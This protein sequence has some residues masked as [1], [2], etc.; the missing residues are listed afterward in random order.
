MVV[1]NKSMSALCNG[2]L[3]HHDP[4]PSCQGKR[5]IF[6]EGNIG[7]GKSSVLAGL[8]SAG[9]CAVMPEGVDEPAFREAL[10]RF[11]EYPATSFHL[12]VAANSDLLRRIVYAL[13]A[14]EKTVVLER[15]P[16][17][18]DVFCSVGRELQTLDAL[19][20]KLCEAMVQA[21]RD[22]LCSTSVST[23]MLSLDPAA[24][25]Q[26]V[27]ERNRRGEDNM[28][29]SYLVDVDRSYRSLLSSVPGVVYI[30]ASRSPEVV[31]NEVVA[32]V[33]ESRLS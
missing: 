32:V 10:V 1:G 12:Q 11:Q 27:E 24:A 4:V 18:G 17:G 28:A 31:M 15:G 14:P 16:I 19:E 30:D 25:L 20:V 21:A 7:V 13:Q 3:L 26:R 29:L 22:L 9:C 6:L 5:I 2:V 33:V 23:L 8:A